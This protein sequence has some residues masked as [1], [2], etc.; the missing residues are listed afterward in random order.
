MDT[1]LLKSFQTL[2]RLKS[3]TLAAKELEL[4]QPALSKRIKRLESII[5]SSLF[6]RASNQ[7]SLTQA[8]K[9]LAEKAPSLLN[10]ISSSIQE[11]R[12]LSGDIA[13]QLKVATSHYLGLHYL[14]QY[15]E[16]FV[17]NHPEVD[18]NIDFIDSGLAYE[19]VV[20]GDIELALVTFPHIQDSRLTHIDIWQE[21]MQIACHQEHPLL[22]KSEPLKALANFDAILPPA[23]TFPRDLFENNLQE[24]GITHGRVKTASY[25]EVIAKLAACK[26]GWT[27]LPEALIQPPLIAL[28]REGQSFRQM[29]IIHRSNKSL[30]NAAKA[31]IKLL[32][33]GH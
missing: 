13:G 27:I 29:G 6:D 12:D 21:Q 32:Q 18:L 23:H 17:T 3:F 14:P 25:L 15:L 20:S 10:Q 31:F 19:Q 8:G 28:T 5:G 11:I 30:S 7:L 26:M 1:E 24:L 22:N 9:L 16:D 4:T 33:T 2:V